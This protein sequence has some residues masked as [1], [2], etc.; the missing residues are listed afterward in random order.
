MRSGIGTSGSERCESRSAG[1]PGPAVIPPLEQS[2]APPFMRLLAITAVGMEGDAIRPAFPGRLVVGGIGR[3]NAASATTE[4]I[5]RHGPFDAVISVGLAGALP[6]CELS[7][8]QTLVASSCIYAEEGLIGPGGFADVSGLGFTL[9]DF[10]GNAVPVDEGLLETLGAAFPLGPIATVASCSGTD[11][12]AAE[13]VRRTGAMAEAME[14]A[15]VV[16]AARRLG[17]KAIEV[18]VISNTTG[19]RARQQWDLE[20]ALRSLRAAVASSVELLTRSIRR[21]ALD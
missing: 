12:A 8:G 19:D 13:V 2:G 17:Q 3:T 7:I 20:G 1:S 9:G 11:A 21:G 15:A 14:G 10:P 6:G 18:R 5:I 4:A 16:H